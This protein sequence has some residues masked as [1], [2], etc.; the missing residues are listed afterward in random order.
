MNATQIERIQRKLAVALAGLNADY[1]D[2]PSET[3]SY[4]YRSRV[5]ADYATQLNEARR[6]VC[7]V[8]GGNGGAA[9]GDLD[10]DGVQCRVCGA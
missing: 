4:L 1:P 9:A 5:V 6:G 10:S 8:C 7:E 3:P 2:G